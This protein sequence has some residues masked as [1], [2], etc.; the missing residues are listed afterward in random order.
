MSSLQVPRPRG[1]RLAVAT[2]LVLTLSLGA[3]A[4]GARACGYDGQ[5]VDLA[6]AHPSSL[7]VALAIQQAYQ[8]KRL[9]R[10]LPLPGGFGMRR[11]M[12]MLDKL[13]LALGTPS[14]PAAFSLLLVEPGLWAR[15]TV[16]EGAW[17]VQ[18]HTPPPSGEE[19]AVIIG[20]GVLLA[21]QAGRLRPEPAL[22]AG[23]LRIEGAPAARQELNAVW[24]LAFSQ[25]AAAPQS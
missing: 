25:A 6:L 24:L 14:A 10:P 23:L 11:A 20:E 15:F 22:A 1:M 9:A 21:L 13:R 5:A 7:S 19:S 2:A 16:R 17:Q 3:A 4:P 8:A 18:L 12:A